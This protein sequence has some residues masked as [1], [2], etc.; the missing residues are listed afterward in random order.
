MRAE[1][2]PE[3]L[4]AFIEARRTTAFE[5]GVTDC[6]LFAADAVEA[7]T[8]VDPA[9]QYRGKYADQKGALRLIKDAG[10]LSALVPLASISLPFAGRGD[11]VLVE[12]DTGEALGVHIG[13]TIAAQGPDG[14][15]F[16]PVASVVAAWRTE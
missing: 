11:V 16:L 5:W 9:K 12:M 4:A 15:V 10:S 1:H 14:L 8:G 2:W 13:R 7:I 6:T 3:T